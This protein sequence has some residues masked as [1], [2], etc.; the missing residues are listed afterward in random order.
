[1][2]VLFLT[3][4]QYMAKDL[5][6]DRF[7]RFYEIPKVI[8]QAGH[9]VRGVCLKY[10]PIRNAQPLL[11]PCEYVEWN[12]FS[13]GRNWPAGFIGHYRRLWQIAAT[14]KPNVVVG[15][16]DGAHVIMASWVAE[17]LGIPYVVDLYDNFESYRATQIPGVKQLLRRAIRKASAVSVVSETLRMKVI[18]EYQPAGLVRVI[19]NAIPREIFHA[20]GKLAARGRL[21]LPEAQI[22]IGT[23]GSLSRRRGI[24]TLCSAFEI[25]T[26]SRNDLLLVLA[27]PTDRR[28]AFEPRDKIIYLGELAHDRVGDLF[29]ALD[30]GVVCNRNDDFGRYCFPQ[31]LFEMLGCRLPVVAAD[32]GVMRGL[33]PGSDRFLFKPDNAESLANIIVAQLGTRHV[34]ELSI[35]SWR[36]SGIMFENLLKVALESGSR[37]MRGIGIALRGGEL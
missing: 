17:K 3:K 35:P 22:L 13:L 15:A 12:S 7:G 24:D 27:G 20:R 34:P 33:L 2:R 32:V 36:D 9:Q 26:K 19:T 8:A 25:I 28:T 11:R 18:N 5:L 37:T 23:A 30:V 1:M 16:S 31:K 10:W 21:G 4:Q 14:F 6:H 29:S